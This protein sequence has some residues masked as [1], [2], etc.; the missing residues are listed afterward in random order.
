MKSCITSQFP[1]CLL[2]LAVF[3][4]LCSCVTAASVTV[5]VDSHDGPWQYVNGGLNNAYQYGLDDQAAPVVISAAN[6]LTFASGGE[7]TIQYVSGKTSA[8]EE[9]G[10]PLVDGI[11][12]TAFLVNNFNLPPAGF[13][14]SRYFDPSDYPAYISAL[15]GTF[16]DSAGGIIGTPFLVGDL[17]SVIVP[18][19]ATQLQLGINDNSFSD[20]S[21][22]LIVNILGP[23]SVPEPS[24]IVILGASIAVVALR[25]IFELISCCRIAC[26]H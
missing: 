7:F 19:G 15:V 8:G 23:S 10:F 12:D 22:S 4:S 18:V 16:A 11:G 20:N 13:Y 1:T 24:S 9:L 25:R 21:G 5:T 2:R 3:A 26:N 14:P 17:R 6:G